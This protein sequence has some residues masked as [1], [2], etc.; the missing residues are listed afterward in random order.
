MLNE[1]PAAVEH[2]FGPPAV[3]CVPAGDR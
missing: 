3:K 1:V 2:E